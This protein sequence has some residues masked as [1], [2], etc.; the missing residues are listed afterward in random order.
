MGGIWSNRWGRAG[1][2]VSEPLRVTS[3]NSPRQ[4]Q[5]LKT[6]IFLYMK[7]GASHNHL[8]PGA[9]AGNIKRHK[10]HGT[11]VRAGSIELGQQR[12]EPPAGASCCSGH[13]TGAENSDLGTCRTGGRC[14][15]RQSAPRGGQ[16][17][18]QMPQREHRLLLS[19]PGTSSP[20][21]TLALTLVACCAGPFQPGKEC[22]T[23]ARG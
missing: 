15:G 18:R 8:T 19:P 9:G 20:G 3:P 13:R 1:P 6:S 11:V 10:T 7:N 16:S 21:S 23:R 17:P 2:L 4:L 12:P 14:Q 5:G 22:E